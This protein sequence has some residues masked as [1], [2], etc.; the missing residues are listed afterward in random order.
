MRVI[1]M[2]D[3]QKHAKLLRE[4][5]DSINYHPDNKTQNKGDSE[6]LTE[7]NINELMGVHRDTYHK[8]KGRVKR[9]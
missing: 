5:R 6:R 2:L 9:K 7:R 4:Y 8:V 1:D 3:E